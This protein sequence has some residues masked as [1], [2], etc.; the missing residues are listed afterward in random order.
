M[1][2][3]HMRKPMI[4]EAIDKGR[5]AAVK[6]LLGNADA[7]AIAAVF[8]ADEVNAHLSHC[9]EDTSLL[10]EDFGTLS[11]LLD[12]FH[13][14]VD[15]RDADGR[16]PLSLLFMHPALGRLFI[17]RGANV[18]AT[19]SSGDLTS[20]PLAMSLEYGYDWLL[21]TFAASDDEA[22]L[23]A[24]TYAAA[25]RAPASSSPS[26]SSSLLSYEPLN[27]YLST[28]LIYGYGMKAKEV[29]AIGSDHISITADM[30]TDLWKRCQEN[31]ATLKE[32][33]DAFEV[34]QMLGASVMDD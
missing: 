19:D 20:S 26:S 17:T 9:L 13:A 18:L 29:F 16:T 5:A 1:M 2:L 15:H 11:L 27:A 24:G 12:V 31:M 22:K 8:S 28:L 4:I 33:V 14:D 3:L 21:E 7:E 10:D 30:A 6:E 34:L 32:P 25:A 23:Y